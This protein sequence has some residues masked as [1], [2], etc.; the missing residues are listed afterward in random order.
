MYEAP[1]L[2]LVG[3]AKDVILG[4]VSTG[5]DIDGFCYPLEND[6]AEDVHL[7]EA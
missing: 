6:F 5:D 1:T 7:T 4:I 2:N 3:Q